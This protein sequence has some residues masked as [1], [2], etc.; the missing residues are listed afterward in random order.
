MT[1]LAVRGRTSGLPRTTAI[2]IVEQPRA[3]PQVAPKLQLQK[4][5]A[6]TRCA[7]STPLQA[8]WS[9]WTAIE[10]TRARI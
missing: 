8:C 4:P 5:A 6:I 3:P 10:Q 9:N 7:H 2:A 1:L